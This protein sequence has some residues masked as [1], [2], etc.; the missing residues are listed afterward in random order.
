MGTNFEK[1]QTAPPDDPAPLSVLLES[2][3]QQMAPR[4][5]PSDN[6]YK[7]K[8]IIVGYTYIHTGITRKLS[9]SHFGLLK[10]KNK[11]SIVLLVVLVPDWLN[12]SLGNLQ[13][14][15]RLLCKALA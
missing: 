6:P 7:H 5:L 11:R 3:P 2:A 14:P 8:K 1:L 12:N 13:Q 15:G 10:V 9:D 4:K